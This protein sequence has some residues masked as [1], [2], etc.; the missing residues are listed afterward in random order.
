[1]DSPAELLAFD[2]VLLSREQEVFRL[3]EIPLPVL[4]LGHSCPME[5]HPNIPVLRR[6]TG[7]GTVLQ[8]PGCLNFTLIRSLERRP[9][10]TD[11]DHS[12]TVLL[13]QVIDALQLPALEIAGSDILHK[14]RKV[15]GNAQRR[16]RGWLMHH[17]TLLYEPF[18][19]DT[20]T[21]V[22]PEPARQP[23]HRRR[24]TH[25]EFLTTLPLSKE[26]LVTRLTA[27]L[28]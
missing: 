4:V 23:P 26:E 2:D 3:W 19:L 18:D 24:R 14:G 1:M 7:G 22:L 15:S 11:V 6:S 12:Y 28:S 13:A 16:T 25:A 20:V 5:H 10:L 21:R 9:E 17:G 8:G 27:R